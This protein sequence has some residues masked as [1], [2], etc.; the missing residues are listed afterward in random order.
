MSNSP[1]GRTAT[2]GSCYECL[3]PSGSSAGLGWGVWIK[4]ATNSMTGTFAWQ[5]Q[6]V[7]PPP[8]PPNYARTTPTGVV[9]K[10]PG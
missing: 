5:W 6:P 7:P 10:S 8:A 3:S 4:G 1:D 9:F 2:D